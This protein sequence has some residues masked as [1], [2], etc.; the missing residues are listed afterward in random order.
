MSKTSFS[1]KNLYY[2]HS[3]VKFV[4]NSQQKITNIFSVKFDK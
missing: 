1:C 3:K 4:Y 2:S